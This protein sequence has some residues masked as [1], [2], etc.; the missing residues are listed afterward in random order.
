VTNANRGCGRFDRRYNTPQ[1]EQ[2]RWPRS[3]ISVSADTFIAVDASRHVNKPEPAL[4]KH[5]EIVLDR[6]RV[7]RL[8]GRGGMGIVYEAEDLL[9]GRHVALKLISPDLGTTPETRGRFLREARVAS[10]LSH[11]NICT[12]FDL[13]EHEGCLFLVMELLSGTT[14][15]DLLAGR[16]LELAETLELAIQVADGLASAHSRG[17]VHRDLKPSNIFVTHESRAKILDFGL[18]RQMLRARLDEPSLNT[19][20]TLISGEQGIP[21]GTLAYMSPEQVRGETVLP[22]SDIFSFGVNLWEMV[23]GEHPFSRHSRL[24][25]AVAILSA[26]PRPSGE[27][28]PKMPPGLWSIL[29]KSLA[30]EVELRYGNAAELLAELQQVQANTGGERFAGPPT[31]SRPIRLAV[32]PFRNLSSDP[33][34]DYFAEGFAEDL[35]NVLGNLD[36]LK[37]VARTSA[38]H[39]AGQEHDFRKL[40]TQLGAKLILSGSVRRAGGRLRVIAELV[41]AEDGLRLWSERYDRVIEDLFSVQDDIVSAIAGQIRIHFSL[42]AGASIATPPRNLESYNH[43]LK[44]RFFWNKRTPQH[45]QRAA[46][47]FDEALQ[48]DDSFPAAWTARAE[49]Q[50]LLGVYGAQAPVH[51]FPLAQKAAIR[52]LQLDP[53]DAGAH[54]VLG[55]VTALFFRDWPGA[56]SEF[57]RALE[58]GSSAT[59]ACQWYANYC[60]IPQARFS[61]AWEQIWRARRNDPL[62]LAV[63]ASAALLHMVQRNYEQA[64]A[65]CYAALELDEHFSMAHYFLGQVLGLS[66]SLAKCVAE[67]EL[68]RSLSGGSAETLAVLGRTHAVSGNKADALRLLDELEQ[69][70]RKEY[71]SPVL[72]AQILLGLA[73]IDGALDKLTL[74]LRNQSA[75]LIWIG[76]HP[77]FAPLRTHQQFRE[78]LKSLHLPQELN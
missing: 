61:E 14:L 53:L 69:R 20:Q 19:T 40:R 72:P 57:R 58:L 48:L 49:T 3:N 2:E 9:L 6:F 64:A 42:S 31:F 43:F 7:S 76:V 51:C 41:N 13:S 39:F 55:S 67:L 11:S 29:E 45:L 44:G 38:G 68:A 65:E 73:D 24:E 15:K 21:A 18:A 22:Q 16:R 28:G 63:F 66:G 12:I 75:D 36:G 52:S 74:A 34:A 23:S 1:F 56:E 26:P 4:L 50:L 59:T 54:A 17:I 5:D 27:M 62:S 33:D 32:L 30:K 37:V 78:I 25:T 71:V 46:G 60:L 8:L 35:T 10:S 70:A 47:L 77:F